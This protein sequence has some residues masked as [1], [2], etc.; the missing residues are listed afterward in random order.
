MKRILEYIVLW[1]RAR[2]VRIESYSRVAT[3]NR[4]D[5]LEGGGLVLDAICELRH[6]TALVQNMQSIG[7]SVLKPFKLEAREKL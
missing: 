1:Y 3:G 4:C 6:W 7:C 5:L 2:T